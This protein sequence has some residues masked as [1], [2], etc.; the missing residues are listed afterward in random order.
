MYLIRFIGNSGERMHD[1]L[2][3]NETI[4]KSDCQRIKTLFS[5]KRKIRSTPILVTDDFD[6]IS[7]DL[8]GVNLI[9][10]SSIGSMKLKH[11]T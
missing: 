1:A 3:T 10:Y 7:I 6:T 2:Y 9:F 4:W 5:T 11:D 8:L